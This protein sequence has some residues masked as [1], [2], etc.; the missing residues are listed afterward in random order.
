ME[1]THLFACVKCSTHLYSFFAVIA[2]CAGFLA[3]AS[4]DVAGDIGPFQLAI[5]LTIFTLALILFWPENYG[6]THGDAESSMA[7]DIQRALKVLL[8]A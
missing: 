4:S 3:Q 2:I 1:V 8:P 7:D 5:A 6:H